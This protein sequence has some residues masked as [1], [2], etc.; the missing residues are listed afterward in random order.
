[1][2]VITYA[3]YIPLYLITKIYLLTKN[4]TNMN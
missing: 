2:L 1:M 4:N 3:I